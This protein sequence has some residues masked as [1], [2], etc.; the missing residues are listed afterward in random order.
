MITPFLRG[1]AD[2]ASVSY[3]NADEQWA[4]F[5]RSLSDSERARIEKRGYA[6]GHAEGK[7]YAVLYPGP[8]EAD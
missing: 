4:G 8:D 3:K 5:S 6:S 2:S 1:F 7:K